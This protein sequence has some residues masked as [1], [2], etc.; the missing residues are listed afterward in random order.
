[1][2]R[3]I[4]DNVKRQLL[5]ELAKEPT[6]VLSTAYI[7]AKNYVEY[8]EDITKAWTT[9]VQQA[10]ITEKVRQ[11]AWVEAY[12]SFKAE[13]EN[14]LKADMVAMLTEIQLEIEECVDGAEGS[15]QFEQGVTNARVQVVDI[16][17]EIINVYASNNEAKFIRMT[18]RDII[19]EKI[20]A[21][22]GGKDAI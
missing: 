12:D 21:L 5:D 1:M 9:A 11:K 15:P 18:C 16:I 6:M 2:E 14:R 17:E 10:S 19:Q 3:P 13:Y 8:G 20:N 7:Y 4:D 22:R